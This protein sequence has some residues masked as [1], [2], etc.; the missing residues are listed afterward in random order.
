MK[1]VARLDA[2]IKAEAHN[3]KRKGAEAGRELPFDLETVIRV[4][5]QAGYFDHAVYLARKYERH[6]DYLRIQIEDAGK[7]R[8]ALEYLRKL[9]P[10]A[11]RHS[12][13]L[14]L[15]QSIDDGYF[16]QRTTL[17]DMAGFY[18][19]SYPK[20]QHSFSWISALA[21]DS[22]PPLETRMK[23][24]R[25]QRKIRQVDPPTSPT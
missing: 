21:Q 15:G 4:C 6:D 1:D 9:G 2:F 5:R 16:S 7:Y 19:R 8:D 11:V 10:A 23:W 3:D 17:D 22:L 24:T 14:Y 18:S 12:L 13:L 25:K 20:K